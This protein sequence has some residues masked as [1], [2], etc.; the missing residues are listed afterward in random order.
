MELRAIEKATFAHFSSFKKRLSCS[1]F[2]AEQEVAGILF[3]LR[4]D[5]A[6]KFSAHCNPIMARVFYHALTESSSKQGP[7][8][9]YDGLC[10]QLH[11]TSTGHRFASCQTANPTAPVSI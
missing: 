8:I 9:L 6:I 7:W 1:C 4:C 5:P 10:W 11:P 2:I 3:Q